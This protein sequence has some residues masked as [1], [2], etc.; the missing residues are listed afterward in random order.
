MTA[1]IWIMTPDLAYGE[2]L[3]FQ[4][5][6]LYPHLT[7]HIMSSMKDKNTIAETPSIILL[8]LTFAKIEG[9]SPVKYIK[10][11]RQTPVVVMA[12]SGTTH[13]VRTVEALSAGAIDYIRKE[14]INPLFAK[15]VIDRIF[16]IISNHKLKENTNEQKFRHNI[17][18]T[19]AS[20]SSGVQRKQQEKVIVIGS[21]TGGPKALQ[22]VVQH[23]PENFD[24]PIL[25]VQHMP[26]GFTHSLA[27]RLNSLSGRQVK[28]AVDRE[29]IK[30][31]NVYIA[32]GDMY[33]TI[34]Q[35]KRTGRL[36][37]KVEADE[38]RTLHRPS[39]DLLFSSLAEIKGIGKIAVVLTG[40][41]KDGVKGVTKLKQND[42]ETI[43]IAE[44]KETA[45]ING[46]PQA[47]I[48]TNLVTTII[49]LEQIGRELAKLQ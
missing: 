6:Q 34:V 11:G 36:Y 33:L 38:K 18:E 26:S 21:S 20:F 25:I 31:G 9:M 35:E 29:E 2:N 43:V 10:K 28:E 16:T 32:P 15:Q 39:V 47:V 44:S 5:Q 41:G 24:I 17:E 19:T 22:E 4:F 37:T 40:M 12:S 49:R 27:Q 45:V 30:K 48:D 3:R 7:V 42:H 8:D 14:M 13:A 23:L 1:T 46:M